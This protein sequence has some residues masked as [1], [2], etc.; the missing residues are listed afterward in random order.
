M[1]SRLTALGFLRGW[2]NQ[3]K[4]TKGPMAMDNSVVTVWGVWKKV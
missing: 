1:F 3:E 2:R 4:R